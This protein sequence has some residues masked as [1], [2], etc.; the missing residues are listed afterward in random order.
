MEEPY[1]KMVASTPGCWNR[2]GR[3]MPSRFSNSRKSS[4]PARR[5]EFH[6]KSESVLKKLVKSMTPYTGDILNAVALLFTQR[7][8]I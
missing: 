3:P 4:W 2:M 7:S 8:A 6:G 5:I 1:T